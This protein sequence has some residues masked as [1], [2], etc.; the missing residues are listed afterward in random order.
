MHNVNF[1]IRAMIVL[2]RGETNVTKV[3]GYLLNASKVI[4]VQSPARELSSFRPRSEYGKI[5][6]C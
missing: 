4:N 2:I 5:W 3:C 1:L 6:L